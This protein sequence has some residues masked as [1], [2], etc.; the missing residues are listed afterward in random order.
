MELTTVSIAVP[1]GSLCDM[2]GIA[3]HLSMTD[4]SSDMTYPFV[5]MNGYGALAIAWHTLQSVGSI[6]PTY[7]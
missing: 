6:W 1:N 3:I 4:D 2:T 5:V 7:L